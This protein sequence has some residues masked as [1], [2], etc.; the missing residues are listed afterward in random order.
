MNRKSIFSIL[1]TLLFSTTFLSA[2]NLLQYIPEDATIV[3]GFNPTSINSKVDVNALKQ[4]DFCKEMMQEFSREMNAEESGVINDA[5]NNPAQYGM[6]FN[7]TSYFVFKSSDEGSYYSYLFKLSDAK[8]FSSF[9]K[10]KLMNAEKGMRIES[11]N[12]MTIAATED[13]SVSWNDEVAIMTAAEISRNYDT[14]DYD[15]DWDT[16]EEDTMEEEEVYEDVIVEEVPE[17]EILEETVE[18]AI[19]A[20]TEEEEPINVSPSEG[21]VGEEMITDE[22]VYTEEDWDWEESESADSYGGESDE[23][24]STRRIKLL[25]GYTNRLFHIP[26]DSTLQNNGK[27]MA[28]LAKRSDANMWLDYQFIQS[29]GLNDMAGMDPSLSAFMDVYQG[30]YTDSYLSATMNFDQG[31]IKVESDAIMGKNWMDYLRLSLDAKMNKKFLKY[32]KGENLF[33]YMFFN[34]NMENVMRGG[35][36][37]MQP[38]MESIPMA[39]PMVDDMLGILDIVV[40]EEALYEFFKGDFCLAF[41]GMR[42]FENMITTYEYDE[43]FNATEKQELKKQTFPEFVMMMSYGNEENLKKFFRLGEKMGGLSQNGLYYEIPMATSMGMNMY[44]AYH[45]GIL[46]FT[47]DTDLV[48]SNL[49][50]GWASNKRIAKEHRKMMKNNAQ[51]MFWDIP[52][53]LNSAGELGIPFGLSGDQIVNVSKQSLESI[54]ITSPKNVGDSYHNNMDFNF[55]NKQ[56][57]SLDQLFNFINEI[58][59]ADKG[60]QSM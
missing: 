40:D 38:M 20:I 49:T 10:E 42:E 35:K 25:D 37:L 39:G 3:I 41:T 56:V 31:Q 59:L 17:E 8:T 55:V 47:N 30:L 33:G 26:A 45:K 13:A 52:K 27:F 1:F 5:I 4:L 18:E 29:M 57:N 23:E 54:I 11:K 12:G 50:S 2:Q 36:D 51:V 14:Y 60:G 19:D 16:F 43:E 44:A 24:Y 21:L 32:L 7:S 58:Y 46:F 34:Y 6:D 53:S 9:F 22:D 15:I 28:H 48:Q